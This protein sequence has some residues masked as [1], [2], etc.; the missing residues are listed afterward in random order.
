MGGRMGTPSG[1]WS[2]VSAA[3]KVGRSATC[4]VR[5]LEG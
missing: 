4:A 3:R 2:E 1:A 5:D